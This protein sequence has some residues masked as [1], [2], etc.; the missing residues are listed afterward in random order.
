ML[1][2]TMVFGFMPMLHVCFPITCL[3]PAGL[4]E[5]GVYRISGLAS[6]VKM[7]REAF[8]TGE[9]TVTGSCAILAPFKNILSIPSLI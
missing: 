2:G 9:R 5:T 6:D 8:D 7:L 4:E 3:H 1:Y